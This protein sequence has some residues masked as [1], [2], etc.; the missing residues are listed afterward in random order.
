M[1]ASATG[2][3]NIFAK[4]FEISQQEFIEKFERTTFKTHIISALILSLLTIIESIVWSLP[5]LVKELDEGS[6]ELGEG[7]PE[8]SLS[9]LLEKKETILLFG[10]LDRCNFP[11]LTLQNMSIQ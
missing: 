2:Q 4:S 6:S 3:L 8:L 1:N 7:L 5:Q 9:L 11:F 10:T